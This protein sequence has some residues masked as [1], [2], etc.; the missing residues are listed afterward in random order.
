VKAWLYRYR[1]LAFGLT[2]WAYVA[3]ALFVVLWT[4]SS[5]WLWALPVLGTL[6]LIGLVA[7]VT[8]INKP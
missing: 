7:F 2:G 6:W 1:A 8:W 3:L 4:S 5:G